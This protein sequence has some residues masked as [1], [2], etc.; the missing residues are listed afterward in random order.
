[1]SRVERFHFQST[2]MDPRVKYRN[3]KAV[4]CG[5]VQKMTEYF[6]NKS[7]AIEE[8]LLALSEAREQRKAVNRAQEITNIWKEECIQ[9]RAEEREINGQIQCQS[10]GW[11]LNEHETANLIRMLEEEEREFQ[12]NLV[13]PLWTLSSVQKLIEDMHKSV[14]QLKSE[15]AHEEKK[16]CEESEGTCSHFHTSRLFLAHRNDMDRFSLNPKDMGIPEEA[17]SW[18]APNDEFRAELLSEYI[19]IDA[20]FFNRLSV[21]REQAKALLAAGLAFGVH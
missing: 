8:K 20:M 7:K 12:Q 10:Y 2:K 17:W 15:L 4:D 21:L 13:R 14:T 16:Y 3:V 9:L 11:I 18:R 19:Q 5:E 1:M 6:K